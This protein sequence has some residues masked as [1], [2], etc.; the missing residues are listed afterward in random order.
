MISSGSASTSRSGSIGMGCAARHSSIA[1]L[2]ATF[3]MSTVVCSR[4]FVRGE[5][6]CDSSHCVIASSS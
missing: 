3:G 2:R 5:V 1:F 4:A 6:E